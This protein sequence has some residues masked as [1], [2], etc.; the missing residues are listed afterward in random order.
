MIR[1][2]ASL[3]LLLWH[4][5][6]LGA[7]PLRVASPSGEIE[8]ALTLN[9]EGRP[10]YSVTRK[11]MPVILPSRLGFIFAD[12]PKF[13]R[14]L[15]VE[16]SS[17]RSVD[18]SWQQPFGEWKTHRNHYNELTVRL[19]ERNAPGRA[20]DVIFRVFDNGVGFRYAF[21]DQPQ[22]K[23]VNIQEELTQFNLAQEGTAWWIPAME[24]NREEYLYHRTRISEAGLTQTPVTFR[25]ES[26]LHV[27]IHEAA[28][29]DYAGMN[30]QK[31]NGTLFK[32][33]LTP[34][35]RGA[36][37]MRD[38]PFVTPW[39][40]LQ[41]ADSAPGLYMS[42]LILNLNE[43]NALG[44][45]SWIHPRKYAGIWW[46][47]HL[48]EQSWA[49]GPRHGA[50]TAYAKKMI[51]FAARNNLQGLL[52][53]GWNV[54]WD[55]DWFANG[56]TFSFT[57]PYPD[58]D[59]AGVAAYAK[60]KG[61]HLI[62]HH[63]TSANVAHYEEQLAA[64]LDLYARLGIDA[65]KT[66]YVSD[67]GGMKVKAPD[68]SIR[69]A[70][71][72]GQESARHHLHVVQEAAKRHIAVNA[73]EPIKDTGLR[74]TWPNWISREGARGMEFNAWGDPQ[75]GPDH[76]PNLVFTRMLAGP[77]DYT[78]GIV[79]LKGRGGRPIGST[80]AAQLVPYVLIYSPI[81]MAADLPE[82]Y[83]K[84]P[85]AMAFIRQVPVDWSDTRVLN[86]E[87]GDYATIAR[88]DSASQDWYV[89]TIT[90]GDARTMSFNLDF[91]DAGKNYMATIWRDG[92]KADYRTSNPDMV[93]ETRKVTSKDSISLRLAAAGGAVLRITPAVR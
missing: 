44:D 28:L 29:V 38:A 1:Q 65:V 41:I 8:V 86:G 91:L 24:W 82:N 74:R 57:Q 31:V 33:V 72:E 42:S 34:S 50:T 75:N 40:T 76:L 13:E 51:D 63:E 43:P 9:G 69:F 71:H 21:P 16:S 79:S 46:G 90:N 23:S 56:E 5:V 39:R 54:G 89:G 25:F 67:A 88:K 66:G 30:L 45:V 4:G 81:Q 92:D 6:A 64:G 87:V 73:H 59:L 70:W 78:P 48:D 47:M 60:R 3:L 80:L 22:L 26:G 35:P 84:Q 61:V 10:D 52:I 27:A 15:T 32:A 19:R 7:E 2:L 18:D 58:F 68:G 85:Q 14:N 55:G 12:A 77:F 36:K 62:G 11:G 49:S 53:E 93:V 17:R 20:L 37:V 83:A